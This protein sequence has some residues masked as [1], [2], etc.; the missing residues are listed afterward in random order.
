V[1]D[2][3]V[4]YGANVNLLGGRRQVADRHVVD[5]APPQRRHLFTHGK[6]L[7]TGLHERAILTDKT[8]RDDKRFPSAR[9]AKVILCDVSGMALLSRIL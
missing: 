5:H 4:Y 3:E 1:E 7:S 8:L 6:L 9:G 2:A